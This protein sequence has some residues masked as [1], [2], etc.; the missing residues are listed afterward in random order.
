[1]N[2]NEYGTLDVATLHLMACSEE[3]SRKSHYANLQCEGS[4][5]V[6]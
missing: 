5:L 6:W 1:M 3:N 4:G 2:R